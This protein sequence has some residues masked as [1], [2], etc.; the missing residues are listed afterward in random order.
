VTP[1]KNDIK[2]WP[3]TLENFGDVTGLITNCAKIQV[4]PIRCEGIDLDDILH[5]FP[6]TRVNIPM[7]YL[8]LPLSVLRLKGIHFQPLEDKVAGKL[9]PWIGKHVTMAGHV[10]LVEAVLTSMVIYYITVLEILVEMLM[11]IDS[12][13]QT[14]LWAACDKVT[15]EKCKVIWDFVCKPKDKG[16][17]GILN[18]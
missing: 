3:S 1:N 2:F 17:L 16:G 14:F 8:S 7:K 18:L 5:N 12:I 4:D 15:G 11:K 6:V 9:V 13:R 10:T